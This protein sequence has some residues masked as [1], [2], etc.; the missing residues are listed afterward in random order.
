MP[1]IKTFELDPDEEMDFDISFRNFLRAKKDTAAAVDPIQVTAPAGIDL[2][3]APLIDG[4]FV[5]LWLRNPE[6]TG[7]FKFKVLLNTQGGRKKSAEITVR[8]R[9]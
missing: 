6:R 2:F 3:A 1:S 7:D 4:T 5:K 9:E 8:V